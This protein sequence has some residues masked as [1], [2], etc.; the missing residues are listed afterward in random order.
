MNKFLI[1][2]DYDVTQWQPTKLLL[3]LLYLILLPVC[4][5]FDLL[6]EITD[7]AAILTAAHLVLETHIEFDFSLI[8]ITLHFLISE[9]SATFF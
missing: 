9:S 8:S 3:L 4:L 5:H 7:A 6:R 1:F 2:F